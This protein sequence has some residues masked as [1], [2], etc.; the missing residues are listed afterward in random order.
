MNVYKVAR[1]VER[2]IRDAKHIER[3]L[4][5]W[6]KSEKIKREHKKGGMDNEPPTKTRSDDL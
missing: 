2:H 1:W 5:S 4:V 6:R 3:V